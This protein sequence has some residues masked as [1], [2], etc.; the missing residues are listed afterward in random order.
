MCIRTCIKLLHKAY[1]HTQ[2]H[3]KVK[4]KACNCCLHRYPHPVTCTHTE[5]HIQ[6]DTCIHT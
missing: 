6:T 5:T 1:E 4:S 2:T 3:A